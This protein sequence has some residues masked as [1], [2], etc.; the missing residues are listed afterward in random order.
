MY[1]AISPK[2]RKPAPKRGL[3]TNRT[4]EMIES[5]NPSFNFSKA[6]LTISGERACVSLTRFSPTF[7]LLLVCGYNPWP[8]STISQREHLVFGI[9]SSLRRMRALV[10]NR[11]MP[12]RAHTSPRVIFRK[13]A[14]CDCSHF[15]FG[16]SKLALS[17]ETYEIS[18]E[19]S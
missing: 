19:T 4:I 14:L 8:T 3:A 18:T 7:Q 15:S 17:T 9:L 6:A 11:R 13:R 12:K 5:L 10:K 2:P 1:I 16:E